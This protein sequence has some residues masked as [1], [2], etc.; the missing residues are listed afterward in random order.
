[1]FDIQCLLVGMLEKP[2]MND[3]VNVE[4]TALKLKRATWRSGADSSDRSSDPPDFHTPNY[5]E[6]ENTKFDFFQ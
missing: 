3:D 5:N 6:M 4:A 2:V 1:M